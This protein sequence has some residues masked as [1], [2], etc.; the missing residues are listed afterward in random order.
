M[1][2]NMKMRDVPLDYEVRQLL[3]DSQIKPILASLYNSRK[4]NG[5]F[6]VQLSIANEQFNKYAHLQ[7]SGLSAYDPSEVNWSIFLQHNDMKLINELKKLNIIQVG[8]MDYAGF[9]LEVAINDSDYIEKMRYWFMDN[10]DILIYGLF[11]LDTLTGEAYFQNYRYVFQPNMGFYR[12]MRAF[13][14]KPDHTLSHKEI[15]CAYQGTENI[16]LAKE[17]SVVNQIIGD[18]RERLK[19]RGKMSN[20]FVPS[21]RKYLLRPS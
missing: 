4:H 1:R 20:L 10:K 15:S 11:T 17:G 16:S 7:S 18:L 8:S 14:E 19:M 2:I 13:L 5:F 3:R 6:Q 21:D 9:C 12:V